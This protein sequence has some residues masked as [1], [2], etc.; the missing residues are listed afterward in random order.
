[1]VKYSI[2][3]CVKL[4]EAVALSSEAVPPILPV[5]ARELVSVTELR[6][7]NATIYTGQPN[8]IEAKHA[9]DEICDRDMR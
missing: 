4:S 3:S 6:A 2:T 8:R 1:M 5:L 7:L 9:I